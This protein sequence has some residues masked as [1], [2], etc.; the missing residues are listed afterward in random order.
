MCRPCTVVPTSQSLPLIPRTRQT[1]LTSVMAPRRALVLAHFSWLVLSS[2]CSNPAIGS[3]STRSLPLS[4]ESA[5]K[6][7][8]DEEVPTTILQHRVEAGRVRADLDETEQRPLTVPEGIPSLLGEQA[9][10]LLR[11]DASPVVTA[12]LEVPPSLSSRQK[13]PSKRRR[14]GLLLSLGAVSGLA[15]V[16]CS[17]KYEYYANMM[18]GN[19]IRGTLAAARGDANQALFFG[20]VVLSYLLG[21]AIYRALDLFLLCRSRD[22]TISAQDAASDPVRFDRHKLRNLSW[23]SPISLSIFCCSDLAYRWM[24]RRASASASKTVMLR[25]ST[26]AV[27]FGMVNAAAQDALST[28][29][30]AATGHITRLGLGVVDRALLLWRVGHDEE[31]AGVGSERVRRVSSAVAAARSSAEATRTSVQFLAAL[32]SSLVMSSVACRRGWIPLDELDPALGA[33]FGA[34]YATLLF[35]YTSPFVEPPWR[36][37]VVP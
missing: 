11:V 14:T 37:A 21:G 13:I 25:L 10:E 29:T 22:I 27:G 35:W 6:P 36:R 4:L 32:I 16:L 12:A 15:H 34:L 30:N 17:F 26:L 18:T 24:S 23:T 1:S 19:T 7:P 31:T 2:Q 5:S 20:A 33:L 8:Y 3:P 9:P 28:V